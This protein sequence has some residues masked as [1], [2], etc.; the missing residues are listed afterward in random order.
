MGAELANFSAKLLIENTRGITAGV[1]K[2]LPCSVGFSPSRGGPP[3]PFGKP[4]FNK[5]GTPIAVTKNPSFAVGMR[6]AFMPASPAKSPTKTTTS[7]APVVEAPPLAPGA[8][9]LCYVVDEES[10]IR[11][12]LSLVLHGSGIDAVEFPDGA[13]L[14]KSTEKRVPDLIFHNISLDS[15]DAIESMAALGARGFRGAVQL[16]SNRGAAVLEHVKSIGVEH[17]LNMLQVLKKPYETEAIVKIIQEHK[18]GMPAAAARI[19]LE[20]ALVNKWIEFWYQPKIDLRKKQLVGAEAYARARHPQHGVLL[21][22]AFMPGAPEA[23]VIRLSELALA[24]ALKTGVI[25]SKLGVNIPLSVNIQPATLVKLPIEEIVMAHRPSPEKWPGL[26]IDLREE[27]I[28]TDLALACDISKRLEPC[29]V[30]LAIDEFGGGYSALA[31]LGEMPFVELKLAS[32]FITD[33]GIDKVN[34]PQCKSVID[35][36]HNYRRSAVAMGIEKAADAMALASMGCDFGQ[37]FL[38]GQP[39]PEERFIALLRQRSGTQARDLPAAA[40]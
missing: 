3:A 35:L 13:A 2:F 15:A 24:S 31:R 11:Q 40:R 10:S 8:V 16:T 6:L 21:P 30:R 9:S 27:H 7:P 20:Q 5:F 22:G 34:M 23:S 25:F 28:I 37:G 19:E 4:I 1:A 26:I 18:L 14:R 32:K 33:C 29:N 12:F 17:K 36:A 39:M 38:L